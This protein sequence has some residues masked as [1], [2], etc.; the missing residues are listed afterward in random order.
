[1]DGHRIS[2]SFAGDLTGVEW[3]V[4]CAADLMRTFFAITA[5]SPPADPAPA[6]ISANVD[7]QAGHIA[8]LLAFAFMAF[9][10]PAFRQAG[11]G[12]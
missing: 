1:M 11:A 8:C 6:V 9:E 5:P 10:E 4:P 3:V 12:P 2:S 7:K